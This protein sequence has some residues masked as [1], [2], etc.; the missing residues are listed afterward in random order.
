MCI[1]CEC[2]TVDCVWVCILYE[3][4]NV[5]CVWV[6]W[7][8]ILLSVWMCILFECVNIYFVWVCERI[9]S[10]YVWTSILCEF[11]NKYFVW[12]C[13]CVNKYFVWVCSSLLDIN[14]VILRFCV[15]TLY[16]ILL[17]NKSLWQLFAIYNNCSSLMRQRVLYLYSIDIPFKTPCQC[18]NS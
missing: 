16:I 6:L 8:G 12:V 17:K 14:Y 2:V 1:L 4:V 13:E 18:N 9:F 10:V 15:T 3:C 7:T 5:Y 11:V